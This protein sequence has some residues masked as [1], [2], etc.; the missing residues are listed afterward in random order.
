M[1]AE[2]VKIPLCGLRAGAGDKPMY[3]CNVL[4]RDPLQDGTAAAGWDRSDQTQQI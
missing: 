2:V 1:E 4:P 3:P